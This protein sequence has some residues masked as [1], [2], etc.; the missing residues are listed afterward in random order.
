MCDE[1][2][3]RKIIPCKELS[4]EYIPLRP[5]WPVLAVGSYVF[6]VGTCLITHS[7]IHCRHDFLFTKYT[8]CQ[9]SSS[10]NDGNL[11]NVDPK[12]AVRQG[13]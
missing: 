9:C 4:P 1:M 13:I 11:G 6:L 5:S 10:Q 3:P 8:V 2:A 7:Q 12:L